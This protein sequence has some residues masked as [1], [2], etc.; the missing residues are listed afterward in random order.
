[1]IFH[2]EV[3]HQ[4]IINWADYYIKPIMI[5]HLL[6][7]IYSKTSYGKR[8]KQQASYTHIVMF[9]TFTPTHVCVQLSIS[10][11]PLSTWGWSVVVSLCLLKITPVQREPSEASRSGLTPTN[12]SLHL[13]N[14]IPLVWWEPFYH[15]LCCELHL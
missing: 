15:S 4:D 3:N 5:I 8:R 11:I 13:I 6:S 9:H 14:T 2:Q 1:M 12:T 10:Y 7:Q